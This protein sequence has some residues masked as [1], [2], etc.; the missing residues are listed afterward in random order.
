MQ[1]VSV[2]FFFIVGFPAGSLG[3]AGHNI[4]DDPNNGKSPLST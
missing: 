2:V 4:Y 3:A 1:P